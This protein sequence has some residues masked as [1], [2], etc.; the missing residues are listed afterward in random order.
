MKAIVCT[1]YGPPE[2]LVLKD[3]PKPVPKENDVLIKIYATSVTASDV[4]MRGLKATFIYKMIIQMMMGFGKPR[5]PI[6]GMVLA[7]VVEN[8]GKNVTLFKQGDPVFAYGA[9]SPVKLRFGTYAEYIC[10][11]EDWNL[12]PKPANITFE[13]AAAIPY[14]GLLAWHF[15]KKADIQREQNILIYGASGSIGTMAIQFAKHAGAVV[16]AVCSS[17]N[18]EMVKSLGADKVIDYTRDDAVSQLEEYDLV[19]DAVGKSKTSAL[20]TASKNVL[21][22]QGK[23]ISVDDGTPSTNKEDFLML[24]ELA[25]QGKLKPIID[26]CFPLE[27]IVQAHTYVEQGHKKGN[28]VISV[29]EGC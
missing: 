15:V 29:V 14:G 21:T 8:T 23:Y 6:L 19:L 18:F 3:V 22:S 9:M 24:K 11:P 7:G 28:V 20:K 10:L 4:L 16:T 5:N 25:E 17:K 27:E 12:A 26:R 2:V 13:E 1:K